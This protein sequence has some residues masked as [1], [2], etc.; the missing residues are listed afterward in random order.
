MRTLF[1]VLAA[2]L[3][4][5]LLS[6]CSH[7]GNIASITPGTPESDVISRAGTPAERHALKDGST[8]LEYPTEPTGF[9]NW[10]VTLGA[11]GTV[12]SVEQLIDEPYFARLKPGMS[13]AEVLQTLGRHSEESAY[14]GLNESVVSWRYREFGNRLLF[15]NAHFDASTGQLKYTSRTPDPTQSG[16]EGNGM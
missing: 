16:V 12:K 6:A 10:R 2:A 5:G 7:F 1:A 13:R 8:A 9:E 11:D 3:T 4:A 14:K 15:F